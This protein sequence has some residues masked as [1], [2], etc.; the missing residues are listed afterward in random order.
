VS[1]LSQKNKGQLKEI[2]GFQENNIQPIQK[3]K[4]KKKIIQNRFSRKKGQQSL[5]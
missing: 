1:E 2:V 5:K 4:I 3:K